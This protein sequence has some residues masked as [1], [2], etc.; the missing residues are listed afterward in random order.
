[1][2]RKR[3][4]TLRVLLMGYPSPLAPVKTDTAPHVRT[5]AGL[6]Y[7][8]VGSAPLHHEFFNALLFTRNVH[9]FKLL[10]IEL[11]DDQLYR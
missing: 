2:P 1:M 11:L 7:V 4:Q 9:S 5:Q 3:P 6:A 10:M 8:L